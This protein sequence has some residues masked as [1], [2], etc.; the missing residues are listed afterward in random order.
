MNDFLT[1]CGS[2]G[3]TTAAVVLSA[4][5]ARHRVE[6]QRHELAGRHAEL[7]AS[8]RA[9]RARAWAGPHSGLNGRQTATQRREEAIPAGG[10]KAA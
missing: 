5:I 10:R 2:S 8:G 1:V 9:L 6:K 3:A 4:L 7:N